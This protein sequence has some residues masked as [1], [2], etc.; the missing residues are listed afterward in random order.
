MGADT[1]EEKLNGAGTVSE[2][3]WRSRRRRVSTNGSSIA[4]GVYRVTALVDG[5]KGSVLL[6]RVCTRFFVFPFARFVLF[7]TARTRDDFRQQEIE[8]TKKA[9]YAP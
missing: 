1:M 2:V 6:G 8:R 4:V 5:A 9:V 3:T 7:G